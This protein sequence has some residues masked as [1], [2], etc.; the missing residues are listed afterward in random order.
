MYS[1]RQGDLMWFIGC[2]GI[3]AEKLIDAA[4]LFNDIDSSFV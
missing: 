4:S 1:I 3:L 2:D